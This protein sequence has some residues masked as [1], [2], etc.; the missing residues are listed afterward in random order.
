MR[1]GGG[2]GGA[3]CVYVRV[4]GWVGGAVCVCL[5]VCVGGWEFGGIVEVASS[6]SPWYER[7]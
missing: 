5:C 6:C 4:G 7:Q 2:W 1:V 3:V